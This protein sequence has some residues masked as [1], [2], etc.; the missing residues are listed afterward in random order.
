MK[1]RI[2]ADDITDRIQHAVAVVIERD[3]GFAV[4]IDDQAGVLE[5]LPTRI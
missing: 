4:A 3:G 1:P 5:D 2:I